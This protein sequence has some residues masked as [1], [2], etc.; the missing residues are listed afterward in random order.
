MTGTPFAPG[1]QLMPRLFFPATA[2]LGALALVPVATS[3][4]AAVDTN[5]YRE[6][7]EFL[8][9]FNRV[10]ADYVDKVDDKTLIKG[11]ISGMLASLDP[12]SSYVDA[13]DFDNLKIQTEGNYGGLGL[14]VSMEDGAIKVIAPQEDTPAGRAGIK[15]GD[16]ITHIDGK[17]IY[18]ESLDEA[19]GGMRGKPGSKVALTLV[20]PGRDKPI[21]VTLVREVIVQKPVK[22]EVRGQ[23]GYININTFSENTGAD[24]RAAIMAIYKSLGHRPLGYVVDLRDNGGGLL[25]QAI[26]VGDAFLDHGEIVSQRGRE[27]TDVERYYARPGD[28]AHGLPVIVLTNAGTASASEIVAGALQDHHRALIMGEKTFGKGSVQTVLPLGPDTALRLT[29]AR[30]YTPSGRS[31]QEGGIEPDIR[32]PQLTDPDYKT[33]PVFREA[34]LRRHLINEVKADNAILEEDTKDD[35]RFTAT[36]EQLKKQGVEDFQLNY[37]LRTVARLGGPVQVA[38]ATKPKAL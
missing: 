31:V 24:T 3:A 29:T 18:G 2:L 6:F 20:R 9:V 1:S 23:V 25:T 27:K 12:H 32:V 13:L 4:M 26:A 8:D 35:P 22:W 17:L 28:D 7:D 19:I 15:S 37:A 14:T 10:K 34:D 11:A 33:R 21:D 16:Y 5:S 36:P 38:A 30:Y